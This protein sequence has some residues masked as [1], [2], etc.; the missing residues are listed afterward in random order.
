MIRVILLAPLMAGLLGCAALPVAHARDPMEAFQKRLIEVSRTSAASVV[1]IEAALR[2][3]NRR[4]SVSG[5]GFLLDANGVVLTNEHVVDRAEKVTVI[6]PGR[7]GRYPAEVVGTDKQ[8]DLAVL[9]IE[10]RPG[11][12]PFVPARLGDSDRLQV[13]QWVIAIGNPYGL[14]G[15]VSLGIVSAKGRDLE[16]ANMLND[17]IQTDAMIDHG[18]S[19]GP[20]M[21]LTG[22]VVGVN[23]RG[24]G[25][26]IGFTIPI[27]TAKQ[28][29]EDLLDRGRIARGYLGISIQ[30]LHRELASHWGI[31]D[32]H[33]VIVGSVNR[34]SPAEHAGLRVGDIITRLDGEPV[35]AE[36]EE[37]LGQFQRLV[38]RMPVGAEIPIE[39]YR[40]GRRERLRAGL[41]AQPKV[42]PDE[43]E[44]D[45]GFIVQEVTDM[46]FRSQRLEQR[47]GVLVSFVDRG[48]EADE[49][50]LVTGDLIVAVESTPIATIEDFRGGMRALPKGR[51]F[52]LRALRGDHTRFMLV[53]PRSSRTTVAQP[54][55]RMRANSHGDGR[56]EPGDTKPGIAEP[57]E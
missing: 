1:H 34:G 7:D 23:S 39:V 9:R 51:P 10:P 26:G 14:D 42:V 28:V 48:S 54:G 24:Q 43:E 2:V 12:P 32:V 56:V 8:T 45:L 22:E 37:D 35:R 30:P 16:N 17:F 49:A 20:L 11:E 38:A 41:G 53:V 33:G 31:P 27:N 6:V 36:K 25:R 15:T 3:N 5:S 46:L 50:G 19:G 4:Q 52:L 40:D 29:A 55:P 18:S 47:E 21:N 44:S 57:A 13:G